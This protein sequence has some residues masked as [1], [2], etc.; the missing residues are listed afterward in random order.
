MHDNHIPHYHTPVTN[1]NKLIGTRPH[2]RQ[3]TFISIISTSFI[4]TVIIAEAGSP[5]FRKDN[6]KPQIKVLR[7][8][9]YTEFF[10]R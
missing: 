1:T 5:Q 3:S 10:S 7:D 8:K 9:N 2:S 6:N 4:Q